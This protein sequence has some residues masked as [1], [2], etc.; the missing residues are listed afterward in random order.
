[1]AKKSAII[2]AETEQHIKMLVDEAIEL[3]TGNY[4][5]VIKRAIDGTLYIK[6]F[7]KANDLLSELRKIVSMEELQDSIDSAEIK[8]IKANIRRLKD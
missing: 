4:G 6:K 5:E 3:Y 7:K 8:V 1:M 2:K